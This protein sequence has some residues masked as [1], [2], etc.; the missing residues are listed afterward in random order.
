MF[1]M[2]PLAEADAVEQAGRVG[3]GPVAFGVDERELDVVER[4][5]ALEQMELL[6]DESDRLRAD[7]RDF[8]FGQLGRV[9]PRDLQD[10]GV[11]PV[12]QPDH[13]EQRR[14]A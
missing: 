2:A 10:A 5:Q 3:R 8:V 12:E 1:V 13:V 6:E 7:L 9:A 14:L 4:S 11:G